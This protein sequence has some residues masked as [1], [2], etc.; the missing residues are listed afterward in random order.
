MSYESQFLLRQS[1]VRINNMNIWSQPA[2]A[3]AARAAIRVVMIW[4][5]FSQQTSG[6]LIPI[7]ERLNVAAYLV[8]VADHLPQFMTTVN[9]FSGDHIQQ[10]S[11][12][13]QK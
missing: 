9:P 6:L 13:C 11:A 7:K 2:L 10:D 1:E 12:P 5:I 8:I 3:S 4:E